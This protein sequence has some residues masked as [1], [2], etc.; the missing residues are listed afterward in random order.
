[1]FFGVT[2]KYQQHEMGLDAPNLHF[3]KL[4]HPK[5]IRHVYS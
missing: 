3:P 1:M 2:E 4:F 5:I